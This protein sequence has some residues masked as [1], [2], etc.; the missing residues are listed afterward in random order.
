MT[1]AAVNDVVSRMKEDFKHSIGRLR[2]GVSST[3]SKAGINMNKI[4]GLPNI[5][6]DVSHP[7]K[8]LESAF[9]QDKFI[10]REL[11]CIVCNILLDTV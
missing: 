10:S 8:G 1:Q 7:F 2:A 4:D 9:L 6:Q 5:P 11:Q 3:L